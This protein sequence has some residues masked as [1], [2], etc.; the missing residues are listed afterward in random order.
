[1]KNAQLSGQRAVS[2]TQNSFSGQRV[3]LNRSETSS[4]D[5]DSQ[6][7]RSSSVG[8]RKAEVSSRRRSN[9][10]VRT[11][12]LLATDNTRQSA[13]NQSRMKSASSRMRHSTDRP[14]SGGPTHSH[15][16]W[17]SSPFDSL[18]GG[19]RP[20]SLLLGPGGI[21][22][23]LELGALHFLSING[24]LSEIDTCIG[25]S[26]GSIILM[27]WTCGYQFSEITDIGRKD[28]LLQGL[29]HINWR[30]DWKRILRH[31]GLIHIDKLRSLFTRILV[32][33][34]GR[35]PTFQEHYLLTGK[36][37]IVTV[38]NFSG[39]SAIY[40]SRFTSPSLS[41]VDAVIG[42]ACVPYL[43]S[44]HY[45][46]GLLVFDGALSNPF[47]VEMIDDGAHDVLTISVDTKQSTER[48][49]S[50]VEIIQS[51]ISEPMRQLR[52]YK[53]T[54]TTDRC[55]HLVLICPP[56]NPNNLQVPDEERVEMFRSGFL[57]A[58]WFINKLVDNEQVGTNEE[59]HPTPDD[60]S[61]APGSS[62]PGSS[63]SG[64]SSFDLSPSG[65]SPPGSS[66]SG[67]SSSGSLSSGSSP[68]GSSPSGSSPSG[69][70]PSGSLSSGSSSSGLSSSAHRSIL[71]EV[72]DFGEVEAERTR[73]RRERS[74]D[75]RE[76]QLVDIVTMFMSTFFGQQP[77]TPFS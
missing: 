34:I 67:P 13:S 17:I 62:P 37:F 18:F 53:M 54:M 4:S 72:D 41:I 39:R 5:Q 70:S 28:E 74:G 76:K 52:L 26:V 66:P 2:N 19:W 1:M 58:S 73:M 8:F 6:K 57:Q 3:D 50:E 36:T 59:S 16:R 14:K 49:F 65:S 7:G 9:F 21:K 69:S 40:Y 45:I 15:Q 22:G 32:E 33:K 48:D 11:N 77:A 46:N 44:R 42:S 23:F 38:H 60:Q 31:R 24:F 43:F 12:R 47:P 10:T 35:V 20:T 25:V 63:P 71:N 51:I 56:I 29:S 55:R 64:P 27:F 75:E 68:P 61:I 30:S